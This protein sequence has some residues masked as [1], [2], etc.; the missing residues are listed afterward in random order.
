VAQHFI[1][2]F[3]AFIQREERLLVLAVGHA[4]DERVEQARC[5]AHQVLVTT[6]QRIESSRIN[7]Y[8]HCGSLQCT[9]IER[10]LCLKNGICPQLVLF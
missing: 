2:N 8:Y 5:A 1:G 10:A 7:S 4:D 3:Q 6:G 9:N